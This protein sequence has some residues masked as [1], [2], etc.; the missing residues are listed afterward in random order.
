MLFGFVGFFGTLTM[1][2]WS[3]IAYCPRR[4]EWLPSSVDLVSSLRRSPHTNIS[5]TSPERN[6]GFVERAALKT[7]GFESRALESPRLAI[8]TFMNRIDKEK[9]GFG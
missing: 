7:F 5:Y 6:G 3:S 8:N 4:P 2:K 1:N 9:I